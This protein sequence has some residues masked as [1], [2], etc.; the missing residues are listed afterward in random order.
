MNFLVVDR[1]IPIWLCNVDLLM[2][3]IDHQN[4]SS[5]ML[6][7]DRTCSKP[8]HGIDLIIDLE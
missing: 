1:N 8:E 4:M 2:N 3:A 5:S 6:S 7:A